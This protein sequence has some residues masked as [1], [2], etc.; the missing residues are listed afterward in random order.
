MRIC[1]E[2]K[3]EEAYLS[4]C[5]RRCP[6]L[7]HLISLL[8][9][10]HARCKHKIRAAADTIFTNSPWEG[11][12]CACARCTLFCNVVLERVVAHLALR[13][14]LVG[15]AAAAR[16]HAPAAVWRH[17]VARCT[18]RGLNFLDAGREGKLSCSLPRTL[19]GTSQLWILKLWIFYN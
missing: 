4:L 14:A 1:E 2:E 17:S 15:A 19:Q 12:G 8:H 3:E 9:L 6:C 10:L 16:S 11:K 7:C 13:R 5:R 18:L